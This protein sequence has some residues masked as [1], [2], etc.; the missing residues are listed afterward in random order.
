MNFIPLTETEIQTAHLIKPGTYDY[1][2]T[3]SEEK[4]SER[5]G[6]DYIKLTLKVWD[7]D[8]K[9]HTLFTGLAFIKILKHFCDVN[10][11]QEEYKSGNIPEHSFL[12]KN[13]GQVVVDI[14][15]EKPN[16]K[17]G[18]FKAQNVVRDYVMSTKEPY[19]GLKPLPGSKNYDSDIPF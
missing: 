18:V 13:G 17:G 1:V 8:G 2:V 11:M 5:T 7:S 6:K 3:K 9:E 15:P 12:L 10:N 16:P 14:D 4:I 19:V